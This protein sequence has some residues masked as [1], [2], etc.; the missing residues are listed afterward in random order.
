MK[1]IAFAVCLIIISCQCFAGNL[2]VVNKF[3][4]KEFIEKN[5]KLILADNITEN[6]YNE[7]I[8]YYLK[9]DGPNSSQAKQLIPIVNSANSGSAVVGISYFQA[10]FFCGWLSEN[11]QLKL[12]TYSA[13]HPTE[14]IPHHIIF[15]LATEEEIKSIDNLKFNE[16]TK[17]EGVAIDKNKK[18]INYTKPNDRM[19]F[20]IIVS[21]IRQ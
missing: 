12:K 8:N 10:K 11:I 20:R 7:M 3:T 13:E 2:D 19:S 6:E 17:T 21:E 4:N 14:N 5:G 16:I 18:T 9:T 1:K 15:K